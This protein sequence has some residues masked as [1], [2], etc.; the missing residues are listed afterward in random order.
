LLCRR[1]R[2]TPERT[3]PAAKAGYA[4]KVILY[5]QGVAFLSCLDKSFEPVCSI[6]VTPLPRGAPRNVPGRFSDIG[7][8]RQGTL[9]AM[10]WPRQIVRFRG[11]DKQ[12]VLPDEIE[13][14]QEYYHLRV[15]PDGRYVS[16]WLSTIS[17]GV[18]N[19]VV[20]V[21]QKRQQPLSLPCPH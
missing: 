10:E 16:Y 1:S 3:L 11:A 17:G 4:R 19:I 21:E 9:Y 5:D 20:D 8:D 7:V 15:A 6:V 14:F 18:S 12:V 13:D 2:P